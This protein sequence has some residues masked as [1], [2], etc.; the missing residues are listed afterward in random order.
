[1]KG[2]FWMGTILA[3][4]LALGSCGAVS[5]NAGYGGETGEPDGFP[6]VEGD[7]VDGGDSDG[8]QDLEISPAP[9]QLT[10]GE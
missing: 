5:N 6:S 10:A 1:M 8:E 4:V 7:V 9:G 3:C 2:K